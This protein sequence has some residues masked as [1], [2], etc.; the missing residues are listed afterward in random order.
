MKID[1][2]LKYPPAS[3]EI[4]LDKNKTNSNINE[5]LKSFKVNA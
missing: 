1:N 2:Y 3:Q 4:I 5:L